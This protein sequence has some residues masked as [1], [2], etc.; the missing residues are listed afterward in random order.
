MRVVVIGPVY[1]YRGGIAHYTTMLVRLLSQRHTV[2]VISFKRQYPAWLYPGRSDKDPS[3]A[4]LRVEAEYLLD[5]L[6]PLT[7][8]Q[9]GRRIVQ[10][11]P[12]LV[13]IQ[14]WVTF[15]APVI[16]M[17][18]NLCRRVQLPLLFVVHN[19]L[20]HE[21]HWWDRFVTKLALQQ[22]DHFIVHALHEYNSLLAFVPQASVTVCSMPAFNISAGPMPPQ[23]D[24]RK[25]LTLPPSA[26]V[27]LFFGLVREYKGL[28]YLLE[29]MPTVQAVL[30]D[31]RLLIAGEFWENKRLYLMQIERLE[32]TPS[33]LIV[34]RYISN[35]DLP[36]YFSAADV[37]VVPY[38]HVSQSAV[39]SL[40]LT[41]G[42]PIITTRI[43]GLPKVVEEGE[44]GLLVDPGNALDLAQAIIR[45]FTVTGLAQRLRENVHR[46]SR[47]EAELSLIRAIE[48]L[49]TK[50]H[51]D[52]T[53]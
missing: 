10:W 35:E 52:R 20:P 5:P 13:V 44:T 8:W 30:P 12:D 7:W 25:Q 48:S 45:Y 6:D 18:S 39:V 42:M 23:V 53:S 11:K 2:L 49:G 15:W 40:A 32:I 9:T 28:H 27:L 50:S 17:V 38:V 4:P 19:V 21:S 26:P 43:G 37:L 3:Q 16:A 47:T 33:V 34:D 36:T 46:R 1:P 31:V 22:G 14:W 24:S 51:H 29:A 41:F